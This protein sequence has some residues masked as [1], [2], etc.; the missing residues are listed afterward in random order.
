MRRLPDPSVRGSIVHSQAYLVQLQRRTGLYLSA[1]A[2]T[3]TAAASAGHTV[4][5][6][7]RLG[8]AIINRANHSHRHADAL[9]AVYTAFSSLSVANQPPG[10][11]RLGDRGDGTAAGAADAR[12]RYA[13]VNATHVPDFIRFGVHPHCYEFKCYTP[14][15]TS[16]ALG[17]GSRTHGGAASTSDGG[18]FALG[19]TEEHL[20]VQ[21]L[22]VAER[23]VPDDGPMVRA[24][25][26][27]GQ[28]WVRATTDHDYADA[29]R[30]GNPVTLLV[31][32]TT[33]AF[34]PT[35]NAALHA[36]GKQAR[37][38]TTH[39]STVYGTSRAS[40]R[41]FYAHHSASASAAIA[42][43]DATSVLNGAA[44]MSF[45]LAH[46]LAP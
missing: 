40:P 4:L 44:A 19:N 42:L 20:I 21:V 32:E 24:G 10:A 1:L 15:H 17:H 29:Q 36:L 27:A 5:Q 41:G 8:D 35:L 7:D 12:Q 37:A 45:R 46:G 11:L 22:G 3:L 14:F 9:R 31:T 16:P 28:G 2:P 33:G 23:G 34:S 38:P 30:R 43:A 26:R 39:D 13:H 18:R 25:P 6:H